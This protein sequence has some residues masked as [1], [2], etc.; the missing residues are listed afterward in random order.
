[1]LSSVAVTVVLGNVYI[2][3]F[4]PVLARV[5]LYQKTHYTRVNGEHAN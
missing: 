3:R 2:S 4:P 1:M 5:R